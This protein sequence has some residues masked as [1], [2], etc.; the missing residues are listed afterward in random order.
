MKP[1]RL[2][3][4]PRRPGHHFREIGEKCAHH[5]QVEK[6][7]GVG[8]IT[9]DNIPQGIRKNF[10]G[11]GASK[12]KSVVLVFPKA[13]MEDGKQILELAN[14]LEEIKIDGKPFEVASDSLIFAEILK[15]I[16][17]DG[18]YILFGAFIGVFFLI[19]L[20]FKS[21][22]QSFITLLPITVGI[23]IGA[24]LLG[25]FN[26]PLDFIN[27]L[28]FP[29]MVGIGIDSGVHIFHRFLES[30]DPVFAVQSTGEAVSLSTLT[31]FWAF[32][33][34]IIAENLAVTGLGLIAV[35]ML[36]SIY[37]CSIFVLPAAILL[38]K[39]K[40]TKKKESLAK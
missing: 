39:P 27:V 20:N 4:A 37:L 28:V 33:A 35:I 18:P 29:I 1:P 17:G 24:G 21:V 3:F 6:V 25:I 12:G 10:Q 22:L 9:L 30:G 34:L 2:C 32:G 19:L 23:F 26:V 13:D 14:Q 16:Q 7:V 5:Y 15:L 40:I 11:V 8:P 31:T 36:G 38:L